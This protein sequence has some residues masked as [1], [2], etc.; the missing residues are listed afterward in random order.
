MEMLVGDAI[1]VPPQGFCT[2][3]LLVSQ[4]KP[5]RAWRGFFIR[6]TVL[7]YLEL[8]NGASYGICQLFKAGGC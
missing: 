1:C 7:S 2:V 3:L 8:L 4:Q 6:T 5:R